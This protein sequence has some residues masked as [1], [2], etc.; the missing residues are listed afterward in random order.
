LHV[1]IFTAYV[2]SAL[3]ACRTIYT[4]RS[5]KGMD[6]KEAK[7]YDRLV[8]INLSGPNQE[9]N[10]YAERRA[11][12]VIAAYQ[13]AGISFKDNG[14][15]TVPGENGDT[16]VR[17]LEVDIDDAQLVE[18]V[19]RALRTVI[20]ALTGVVALIKAAQLQDGHLDLEATPSAE[21]AKAFVAATAQLANVQAVIQGAR[22]SVAKKR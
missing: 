4:P 1:G 5:T 2:D 19:K 21:D 3:E 13:A 14:V 20:P 16:Y 15:K 22:A 8:R 6:P 18:K 11:A 10:P 9:I 7:K 17:T 12:M